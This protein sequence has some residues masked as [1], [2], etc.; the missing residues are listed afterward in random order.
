MTLH[1]VSQN[2]QPI[3]LRAKGV[4]GAIGFVGSDKVGLASTS[5]EVGKFLACG[6]LA[7][8]AAKAAVKWALGSVPW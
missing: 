6:K 1:I 7:A 2:S 8:A 3:D 5:G 4:A